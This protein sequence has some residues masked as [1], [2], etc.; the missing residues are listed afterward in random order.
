MRFHRRATREDATFTM[1][2]SQADAANG[3]VGLALMRLA[4]GLRD[5][6]ADPILTFAEANIRWS[7][8]GE[9]SVAH[10]MFAAL[11]KAPVVE[12]RIRIDAAHNATLSAPSAS[13][14]RELERLATSLDPTMRTSPEIRML[15]EDDA[16]HW[17]ARH[18]EVGALF[19]AQKVGESAAIAEIVLSSGRLNLSRELEIRRTRAMALR[20]L[21]SSAADARNFRSE[22]FPPSEM[23]SLI[24][25]LAEIDRAIALNEWDAE[26]WNFRAAWC[27][28]LKRFDESIIAAGKA[29]AIRPSNYARPHQNRGLALK[30]LGQLDEARSD[31]ELALRIA[32]DIGSGPE[33]KTANDS[34]Q[35]L[36]RSKA[37]PRPVELKP[38]IGEI[39]RVT[40][41]AGEAAFSE[42]YGGKGS[43]PKLAQSISD[44]MTSFAGGAWSM[45]YVTVLE[46]LLCDM[47]PELAFLVLLAMRERSNSAFE[48]FGQAALYLAANGDGV[49][50]RDAG[51]LVALIIVLQGMPTHVRSAYRESVLCPSAV[52]GG[53]LSGLAS[54]M[55]NVFATFN[56][57][58]AD[59]LTRQDPPT[60][61]ELHRARRTILSAFTGPV[62][63]VPYH[64]EYG[65][66]RGGGFSF[67]AL[68]TNVMMLVGLAIPLLLIAGAIWLV[69]RL[70]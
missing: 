47:G 27:V 60:E 30:N 19:S 70:L 5:L 17:Q 35:H 18:D 1:M 21:H 4:D 51:R 45:G 26:L 55:A 40:K 16:T 14:W 33:A 48:H 63:E 69:S 13:E 41:V 29:L 11:S 44:R 20:A 57:D 9:G 43:V 32:E 8:L 22:V 52:P 59:Y 7:F 10:R 46:E 3:C 15:L 36:L 38:A 25:A 42:W 56:G 12:A 39:I 54:V 67:G 64:S 24:E 34:L 23:L 65:G 2:R 6:P 53:A 58:L 61:E 68:L 66:G 31:F 62:L 28:L 50:Q 49:R 37:A